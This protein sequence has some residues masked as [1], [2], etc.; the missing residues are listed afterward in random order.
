VLLTLRIDAYNILNHANLGAPEAD[1]TDA[2]S[3]GI[4]QYGRPFRDIGTPA[5]LPLRESSRQ[6]QLLL[7]VSF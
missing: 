6:V 7:R 3:F 2:E 1:L 4:A 5:L